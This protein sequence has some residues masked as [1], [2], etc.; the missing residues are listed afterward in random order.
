MVCDNLRRALYFMVFGQSTIQQ[1][2]KD[3]QN[4]PPFFTTFIRKA[5]RQ[6][7]KERLTTTDMSHWDAIFGDGVAINYIVGRVLNSNFFRSFILIL[8]LLNAVI[9]TM[10]TDKELNN[11]HGKF[12]NVLDNTVLTI[13]V[14]EIALKWYYDFALFWK[15]K[16]N[17]LDF[18]LIFAMLIG[19]S[20]HFVGSSRLLR[21]LRVIRAFR[22]M[23]SFHLISG[24]SVIISTIINSTPDMFNIA[25]L[26]LIILIT[27]SVLGSHVFGEYM[28]D[29]FINFFEAMY[30]QW[31]VM[32]REGWLDIIDDLRQD[33][34]ADKSPIEY[35][36]AEG[37]LMLSLSLGAFSI[38]NL[39]IAAVAA[40]MEKAMTNYETEHRELEANKSLVELAEDNSKV[41]GSVISHSSIT[42]RTRT[43]NQY[44]CAANRGNTEE[45]ML[46]Y[47][48]AMDLHKR[49]E[50][51][52]QHARRVSENSDFK[53][54]SP[55]M[56]TAKRW[57]KN[58]F[59]REHENV[60]HLL[61]PVTKKPSPYQGKIDELVQKE[62]TKFVKIVFQSMDD[63]TTSYFYGLR[64]SEMTGLDEQAII[65]KNMNNL[66]V[67]TSNIRM[68]SE[69]DLIKM[70]SSLNFR[71]RLKKKVF[72]VSEK[73]KATMERITNEA[74][75]FMNDPEDLLSVNVTNYVGTNAKIS[76]KLKW[77]LNYG[78]VAQVSGGLASI[79]Q[80]QE[81]CEVN[82]ML[83]LTQ[84]HLT[85]LMILAKGFEDN[86]AEYQ[87]ISKQ[88]TKVAENEHLTNNE[89][90]QMVSLLLSTDGVSETINPFDIFRLRSEVLNQMISIHDDN[91]TNRYKYE[92][93][94]NLL[95]G[96]D[97]FM[98]LYDVSLYNA[99]RMTEP[100]EL[101]DIRFGEGSILTNLMVLEKTGVISTGNMTLKMRKVAQDVSKDIMRRASVFNK[102]I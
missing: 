92:Y 23:R 12:F 69:F 37:Y 20:W 8:I 38:M 14:W 84:N 91:L 65:N 6:S 7:G 40:N 28:P 81:T 9:I 67:L 36:L 1:K 57:L 26:Q 87:T 48:T 44:R 70:E 25:L 43:A 18:F 68:A 66:S 95:S 45:E 61:I 54:V 47:Q 17:I 94:D 11:K 56:K 34:R 30:S 88:I 32:T 15:S 4:F 3:R 52:L 82:S 93:V 62:N 41:H 77:L 101:T 63:H 22:L 100:E 98:D 75:T 76:N 72:H 74:M 89:I 73:N 31:I 27:L 99:N 46:T 71:N 16:W 49:I 83:G 29:R 51:F 10:Q 21:L 97:N 59:W 42:Q 64:E 60:R 90:S 80:H 102:T 33:G 50:K 78:T 35:M 5:T 39:I 96:I 24:L 55:Y 2:A 19:P 58:R 85:T 53:V 86:L 79:P 13:F